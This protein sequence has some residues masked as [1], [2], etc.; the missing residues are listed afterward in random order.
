MFGVEYFL[1]GGPG[2]EEFEGVGGGCSGGGGVDVELE[3]RFGGQFECF[4]VEVELTDGGVAQS[5]STAAVEA[6]VL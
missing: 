6:H 5:F 4:E 1:A 2:R 3:A